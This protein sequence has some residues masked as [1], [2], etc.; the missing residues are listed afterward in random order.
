MSLERFFNEVFDEIIK[1]DFKN[2]TKFDFSGFYLESY[3]C[4]YYSLFTHEMCHKALY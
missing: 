1:E 4:T 3:K 2:S